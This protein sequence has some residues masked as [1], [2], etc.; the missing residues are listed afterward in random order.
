MALMFLIMLTTTHLKDFH[1]IVTSLGDNSSHHSGTIY[2][3]I[4]HFERRALA[5]GE[6][7]VKS[8]IAA[9][10]RRYLFYFQFFA[11]SNFILFATGFYDR[12]HG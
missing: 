6:N 8:N 5:Y 3:G 1:F 10:V 9:D 11:S 7:L 4:A 12:L 2:Q